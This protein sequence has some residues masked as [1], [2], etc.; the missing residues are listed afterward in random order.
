MKVEI[1][2]RDPVFVEHWPVL[3][4]VE[5]RIGHPGK[6]HRRTRLTPGQARIVAYAILAAAAYAEEVPR[7]A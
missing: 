4:I 5:L 2:N 3:R 6:G 1:D 7:G